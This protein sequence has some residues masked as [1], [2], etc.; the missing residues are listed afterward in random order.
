MNAGGVDKACKSNGH[1][2]DYIKFVL[3]ADELVTRRY[4]PSS[5]E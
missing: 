2:C 5:L 4:F 1:L 3:V